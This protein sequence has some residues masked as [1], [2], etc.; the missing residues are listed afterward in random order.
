MMRRCLAAGYVRART[1][2]GDA[3]GAVIRAAVAAERRLDNRETTWVD[4]DARVIE[5]AAD[6]R[7]PLLDRVRLC[8]IV[9]SNLDE[10][11]AVRVARLVAQRRSTSV[12]RT[13]DGSTSAQTLAAIR[14]RVVHLQAAKD[15]LWLDTLCPGM[16]EGIV[17][18]R[19]V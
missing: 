19:R 2:G 15:R 10:F 11:F 7:M 6:A 12:K 16:R 3:V 5:L 1:F 9:S 17:D 8:G 14:R 4:F 18:I 13:P